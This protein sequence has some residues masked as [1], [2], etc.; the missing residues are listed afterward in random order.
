MKRGL[1]YRRRLRAALALPAAAL[2]LYSCD[3]PASPNSAVPEV[4]K[5]SGLPNMAEIERRLEDQ[6]AES[7]KDTDGVEFDL[8]STS[9][10]TV[11]ASITYAEGK[12]AL[13]KIGGTDY[14]IKTI[15]ITRVVDGKTIPTTVEYKDDS[16]TT[17]KT[18]T[19]R[20]VPPPNIA[21]NNARQGL[22]GRARLAEAE[23]EGGPALHIS[24]EEKDGGGKTLRTFTATEEIQDGT[25]TLKTTYRRPGNEGF[26]ETLTTQNGVLT[27]KVETYSAGTT[28]AKGE[29]KTKTITYQKSAAAMFYP[30][31]QKLTLAVYRD[32]EGEETKRDEPQSDGSILTTMRDKSTITTTFPAGGGTLAVYKDPAGATTETVETK[33]TAKGGTLAVHT[34]GGKETLRIETRSDKSTIT[35]K[36]TA[37]VTTKELVIHPSVTAIEDKAFE[38]SGL[39]SVSMG[40]GV[41]SIGSGAF[42]NNELSSVTI[43]NGLQTIE[44]EVF[45]GNKLIAVE[46]PPL[47]TAIGE[48]AFSDNKLTALTIGNS[49]QTVGRGAFQNNE[50]SSVTI[51]NS[52]KTIEPEVFR[53]NKLSSVIIPP[54]VTAIGKNAFWENQVTSLTIGNGL[55]TIGQGAFRDNQLT[56]LTIPPSVTS[57]EHNAF[58]KN[59]LTELTIPPS[60]TVI[61][62]AAFY[63]NELVS[64]SIPASIES[65][66]KLS[67]AQ[68]TTLKIISIT[69]TGPI[70]T[71]AFT[72]DYW[73]GGLAGVFQLAESDGITLI[74]G[75]GVT[76]IGDSA[77]A[78]SDL[79]SVVIGKG[80]RTIGSKAFERNDLTSL[81]IPPSVTAIEK[82]AFAHNKL[83][84]VILPKALS[85]ARETAFN[86]NPAGLKFREP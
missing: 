25:I 9:G 63:E 2:L 72:Y 36:T 10:T 59:K 22:E 44:P 66:G 73:R 39:T 40:N 37:G 38:N 58:A 16:G 43:G 12:L 84:F 76:S 85:K 50:L 29:T 20:Y 56:L 35:T 51:G 54:S 3:P 79:T 27:Q 52:L 31:R 30:D 13:I 14:E 67:F 55:K 74:I 19:S 11:S 41:R 64:V 78:R 81:T 6:Y 69:G 61:G 33:P 77:F 65:L 45:R 17:R 42:R 24:G 57:I 62:G 53:N 1:S 80:V 86:G 48:G 70:T 75:D 7:A 32:A 46:I 49:V 68:N 23:A 83:T 18:I 15:T 5:I 82:A 47:V 21:A 34:E 4:I 28:P 8:S 60:V 71:K 26:T